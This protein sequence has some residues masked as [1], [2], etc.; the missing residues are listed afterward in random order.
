M[1]ECES[2][3]SVEENPDTKKKIKKKKNKKKLKALKSVLKNFQKTIKVVQKARL[4]ETWLSPTDRNSDNSTM[5][6][7]CVAFI[8]I[9]ENLY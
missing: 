1:P 6:Q 3:V 8:V 9:Y 5:R 2:S 4:K 7:Y